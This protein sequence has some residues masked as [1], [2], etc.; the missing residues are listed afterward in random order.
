MIA[1]LNA[2]PAIAAYIADG[3]LFAVVASSV[4]LPVIKR[5]LFR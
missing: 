1:Y 4:I 5:R 2:N 3:I